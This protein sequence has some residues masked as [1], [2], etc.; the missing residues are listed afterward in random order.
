MPYPR[1]TVGHFSPLFVA[2]RRS[3]RPDCARGHS[4]GRLLAGPVPLFLPGGPST[5][6]RTSPDPSLPWSRL[7]ENRHL[8]PAKYHVGITN[9]VNGPLT[10]GY[11]SAGDLNSLDEPRI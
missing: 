6:T 2:P 8:R 11:V 7:S 1:P 5:G 10:C 4:A 9:G 3:Q